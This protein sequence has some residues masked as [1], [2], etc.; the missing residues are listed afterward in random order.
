M[1]F[2]SLSEKDMIVYSALATLDKLSF[3]LD[4]FQ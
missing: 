1:L 4:G 3:F 2:A